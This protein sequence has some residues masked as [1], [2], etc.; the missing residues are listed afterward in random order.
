[1][2]LVDFIGVALFGVSIS[3]ALACAISCRRDVARVAIGLGL[4]TL[5]TGLASIAVG[6]LFTWN[7][8]SAPGLS[9]SDRQR[10]LSNGIAESIYNAVFTAI[11]VLPALVLGRWVLHRP[12]HLR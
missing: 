9:H 6:A 3:A 10:M 5:A 12:S 1:M 7:A 4:L 2:R 11:A 8:M